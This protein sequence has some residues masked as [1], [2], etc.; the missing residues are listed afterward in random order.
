MTSA[1]T[2]PPPGS[3]PAYEPRRAFRE[4]DAGFL[5][6]VAAGLAT[7]LGWPVMWI[8][9][10]L[11]ALTVANGAGVLLYAA[12]WLWLPTLPVEEPAPGLAAAER[13]GRRTTRRGLADI[14]PGVALAALAVGALF[15]AQLVLGTGLVLWVLVLGLGGVALIWRQA[16]E[17]SRERWRDSTGRLDPVRALVGDGGWAA[18][19]RIV[20]GVLM[21]VTALVLFALRSGRLSLA[22]DVL[23]ATGLGLVGV[24]LVAGPWLLRL[25]HDLGEERAQRVRSQERAD[26]AAHLHDSVLQTLALIQKNSADPAQVARLARAQERDLRSWLF[27]DAGPSGSLSAALA[28][29]AAEVE[30]DHNVTVEV[31]TVGDLVLDDRTQPVLLATREAVV[32]AAKHAG[33]GRVDVYAE[34][35]PT[36]LE[37][38]VKDRGRGFDIEAVA[39]DRHGVRG[40]IK[41]RMERHGGTARVM[42]RPGEGTEVVLQMP[43][44]EKA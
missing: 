36:R 33:A 29:L 39:A 6:G 31:V 1:A 8:R 24:L 38:F 19:S 17:S 16:D 5:G 14:G 41:D 30:A 26:V 15:V 27:E 4:P 12:L 32:N 22:V 28:T 37:V 7:H 42:S 11:V 20:V 35:S 44:E 13:S 10:A 23:V 43:L 2:T 34:A 18:W 21:L 25:F 3:A 9:V 40:S